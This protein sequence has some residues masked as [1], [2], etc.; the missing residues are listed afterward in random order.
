MRLHD[1]RSQMDHIRDERDRADK[2]H[3]WQLIRADFAEH[4]CW[5]SFAH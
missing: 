5:G 1:H 3:N 4:V 2:R